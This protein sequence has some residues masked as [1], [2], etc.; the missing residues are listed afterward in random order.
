MLAITHF[1]K[2]RCTLVVL[3]IALFSISAV[4]KDSRT[5]TLD[6]K[7]VSLQQVLE[8]IEQQTPYKFSYKTSAIDRKQTVSVT[9]R[10]ASVSH[11]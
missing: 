1:Q 4:A 3:L 6:M 10:N 8:T 5:I 9:C 7:N 11:H 2:L